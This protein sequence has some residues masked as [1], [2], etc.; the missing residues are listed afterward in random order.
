MAVCTRCGRRYNP[1]LAEE[2][3]DNDTYIRENNLEGTYGNFTN[4]CAGCA[5][6]EVMAAYPQGL[7]DLSYLLDDD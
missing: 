7:E 5:V 4:H 1:S 3:Y 6:E 2:D